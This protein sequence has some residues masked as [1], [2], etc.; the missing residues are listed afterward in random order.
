MEFWSGFWAFVLCV[1][2]A[3]FATLAVKIG[4]SAFFDLRQLLTEPPEESGD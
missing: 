3:L 4:V 1:S 2:L